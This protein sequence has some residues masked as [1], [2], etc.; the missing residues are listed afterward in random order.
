MRGFVTYSDWWLQM[1]NNKKVGDLTRSEK[2]STVNAKLELK[3]LWKEP[4]TYCAGLF[5]L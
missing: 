1:S 2:A 5:A 4:C 3:R